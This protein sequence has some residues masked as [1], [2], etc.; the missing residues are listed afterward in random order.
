MAQD[1][2]KLRTQLNERREV[3]Q[4]KAEKLDKLMAER[5]RGFDAAIGNK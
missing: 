4:D 2:E 5:I 3:K 1:V